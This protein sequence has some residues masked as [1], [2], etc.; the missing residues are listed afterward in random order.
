MD[1]FIT[2]LKKGEV[3]IA[4]GIQYAMGFCLKTEEIMHAESEWLAFS[5]N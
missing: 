4:V 1:P 5:Q 2:F 3:V